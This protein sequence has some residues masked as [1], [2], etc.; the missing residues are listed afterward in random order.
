M[1]TSFSPKK[2]NTVSTENS[3][4]R[5]TWWWDQV[6]STSS[7]H[8]T[9]QE[10]SGPLQLQEEPTFGSSS[11]IFWYIQ[12]RTRVWWS[13]RTAGTASS[14]FWSP[15]LSLSFGG[16][17]R[18]T[19]AWRTRSS[20]EPWGK[21]RNSRIKSFGGDLTRWSLG[22]RNNWNPFLQVLLQAR[23]S[24]EGGRT[25]ACLQVREELH[26]LENGGD[27]ILKRDASSQT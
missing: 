7:F 21:R 12:S 1:T 26:R 14:S 24:G 11:E 19:A 17:R 20:V 16:R 13:G 25:Q 8:Y 3:V 22:Q 2:A 4:W 10:S 23:D 5:G 6:A 15:K 27:W 18:R 9:K